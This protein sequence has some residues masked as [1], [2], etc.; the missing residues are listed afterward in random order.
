MFEWKSQ[1]CRGENDYRLQIVTDD[2]AKY[3]AVEALAQV[4]ID[5]KPVVHA[6]WV[7]G[8]CSRCGWAMPTDSADDFLGEDDN[9]FCYNCGSKMDVVQHE[10]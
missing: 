5:A 1:T 4:L 2:P 7:D 9:H 8:C 10:A 6:H 3:K